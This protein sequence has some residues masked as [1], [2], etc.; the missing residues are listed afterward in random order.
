MGKQKHSNRLNRAFTLIELLVVIAIIALLAALLLPALQSA[1]DSANTIWCVSN[2]KQWGT[3]LAA[4][5]SDEVGRYPVPTWNSGSNGWEDELQPYIMPG[6]TNTV[7]LASGS[8]IK[9][10]WGVFCPE[11]K[12]ISD[13]TSQGTY[14]GGNYYWMNYYG[15]THKHGTG[16]FSNGCYMYN[17]WA[18]YF[19]PINM[20]TNA[21]VDAL[22]PYC[23]KAGRHKWPSETALLIEGNQAG[24][25]GP[26][27]FA[28][29]T[30]EFI[31]S[32]SAV[33]LTNFQHR[34]YKHRRGKAINVLFFDYHAAT[35]ADTAFPE[36]CA[37]GASSKFWKGT[38]DNG[39]MG[40]TSSD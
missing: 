25:A 16:L 8:L 28:P 3:A 38:A 2:L 37:A 26:R 24:Q 4:F 19:G 6:V 20:P 36:S 39:K 17:T 40:S 11:A 27:F 31:G 12:K 30:P 22:T 18:T 5:T 14:I 23:F 10:Y 35:V 34:E 1:K 29:L 7:T 15:Q 21:V 32:G 13:W 9:K 33:D